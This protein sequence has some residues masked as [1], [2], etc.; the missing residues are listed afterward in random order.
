MLKTVWR[1]WFALLFCLACPLARASV[2]EGLRIESGA[3]GDQVSLRAS[4]LKPSQDIR[5]FQVEHPKRVVIDVPQ[6][7]F[8]KGTLPNRLALP[9]DYTGERIVGLRAGQHDAATLRIVLELKENMDLREAR[10]ADEKTLRVCRF[11]LQPSPGTPPPPPARASLAQLPAPREASRE[12]HREA[13]QFSPH[14]HAANPDLPPAPKMGA[15]KPV[16]VIDAGHG[17]QDPGT[18]G[19]S[20]AHEKNVTLHY[21]RLLAATLRASGRYQVALTREDD[22]YLLLR[23]RVL[24]ARAM[25]GALFISLHADSDPTRE[26]RGLSLYT[27]SDEASDQLSANLAARENRADII[28]GM[29]LR[30]QSKEVGDILID[31][32][33]RETRAKSSQFAEDFVRA[34]ARAQVVML[35]KPHRFAGFAVLKAPDIP[36]VLIELGFLTN[37]GEEKIVESDKHAQK[38]VGALAKAIDR[39]FAPLPKGAAR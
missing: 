24:K 36:S 22:R 2:I 37:P 34:F 17:G 19:A 27:I 5:I 31:L 1:C 14:R 18:T 7:S 11:A 35:A 20:G 32:A 30:D 28:G 9:P 38:I 21:A 33:R 39:Y 8:Q 12:A 13:E 3:G 29:D 25:H 6:G 4:G 26:A 15:G 10:C 23:E 16:I